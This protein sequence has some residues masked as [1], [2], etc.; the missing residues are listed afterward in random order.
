[1]GVPALWTQ[2]RPALWGGDFKFRDYEAVM[3]PGRTREVIIAP[4]TSVADVVTGAS[5]A[6]ADARDD[7]IKRL[8]QTIPKL[9]TTQDRPWRAFVARRERS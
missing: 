3:T 1:M 6:D 4:D 5:C 9:P 8:M 2:R 7:S